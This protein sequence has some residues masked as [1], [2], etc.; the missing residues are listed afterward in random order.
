MDYIPRNG[1][2]RDDI[3]T[4]GDKIGMAF[5]F[6]QHNNS[7][8]EDLRE[9]LCLYIAT[10]SLYNIMYVG[11]NIGLVWSAEIFLQPHIIVRH[12]LCSRSQLFLMALMSLP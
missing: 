10:F 3:K 5:C 9:P 8:D 12:H 1:E 7:V 11:G 4:T 6:L 2:C